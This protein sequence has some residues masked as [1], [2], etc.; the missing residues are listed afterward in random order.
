M[1]I[2]DGLN[3][4]VTATPIIPAAPAAP[5]RTRNQIKATA[6]GDLMA[7]RSK[8]K[9][10]L[11]EARSIWAKVP[12]EELARVDGSFHRLAGLVQLRYHLSRE[13]SDRQVRAFFDKHYPA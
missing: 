9:G 10:L 5:V 8:W 1:N 6:L 11:P 7:G 4:E 13:E 12:P 3:A 2:P